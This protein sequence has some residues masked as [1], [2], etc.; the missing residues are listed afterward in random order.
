MPRVTVRIWTRVVGEMVFAHAS[1]ATSSGG[2]RGAGEYA[3]MRGGVLHTL[4]E[5]RRDFVRPHYREA[6]IHFDTLN[7]DAINADFRAFE[8]EGMNWARLPAFATQVPEEADRSRALVLALL[9]RGGLERIANPADL[10]SQGM[11]WTVPLYA[12]ACY[13]GAI[14]LAKAAVVT[15]PLTLGLT[16]RVCFGLADVQARV[17]PSIPFI[18]RFYGAEQIAQDRAMATFFSN[19]PKLGIA[20]ASAFLTP[21]GLAVSAIATVLVVAGYAYLSYSP[22]ADLRQFLLDAAA[23]EIEGP[24]PVVTPTVPILQQHETLAAPR[25]APSGVGIQAP[26]P[27]PTAFLALGDGVDLE[28]DAQRPSAFRKFERN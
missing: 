17:L 6:E 18:S 7:V 1:L 27:P 3:S 12:A 26:A 22:S 8:E 2:P 4:A 5:D 24:R 23:R 19:L 20:A 11:S 16:E 15:A 9:Q 14:L 28:E 13:V 25:A 10:V 21:A